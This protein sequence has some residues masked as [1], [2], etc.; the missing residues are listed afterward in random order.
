LANSF[1]FQLSILQFYTHTQCNAESPRHRQ[2]SGS[3]E[4]QLYSAKGT[5]NNN[6]TTRTFGDLWGTLLMG[7]CLEVEENGNGNWGG[8]RWWCG[9]N[10]RRCVFWLEEAIKSRGLWTEEGR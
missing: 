4:G 9:V 6:S 10:A 1:L 3:G 2:T 8:R 5:G 7:W